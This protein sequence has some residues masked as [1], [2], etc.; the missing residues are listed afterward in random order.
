MKIVDTYGADALRCY[1][2]SS[3]VVQSENLSFAE[4]GVDEVLKK[5]IN[6]LDNV[7]AFYKLYEDPE[8]KRGAS[9]GASST[10]RGTESTNVLDRWILLRLEEFVHETTAGYEKYE[11]DR[12]VRPLA[13]FTEDL[14]VWYLRRS[15]DRL[16]NEGEDKK[17]ALATLRHVLYTLSCVLAPAM[18]FIAED[19]YQKVKEEKDVESVH[20]CTW[21]GGEKAGFSLLALFGA[22]KTNNSLLADMTEVRKAVSL[23]LEKRSTANIKVRQPLSEVR[24]KSATLK[25]KDELTDLIRDELNVKSVVIDPTMA[26]DIELNTELTAELKEEGLVRDVLRFVQD[27][28]KKAGFS[29]KDVAVLRC[30]PE[31]RVFVEKHWAALS[32][33]GNFARFEEG[34]VE[35]ELSVDGVTFR[36]NVERT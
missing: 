8:G 36:F 5:N 15:R 27:L 1:L 7:V 29:P 10:P 3:P 21:P 30:V 22:S 11:L 2:L 23:G 35:N 28:R 14:S 26:N 6:R 17:A 16:K 31:N 9:Y 33:T 18:P 4:A 19:I 25:G 24:I 20:L 13:L 12:A 32:K 34:V